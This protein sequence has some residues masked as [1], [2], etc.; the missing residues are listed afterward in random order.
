MKSIY[1]SSE[2]HNMSSSRSHRDNNADDSIIEISDISNSLL[3]V[4]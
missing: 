2:I 3:S 1:K 4:H